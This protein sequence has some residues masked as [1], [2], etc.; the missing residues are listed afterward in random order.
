MCCNLMEVGVEKYCHAYF[1]KDAYIKQHQRV[2]HAV[3]DERYWPLDTC[4]PL[5]PPIL[6]RHVGRP[7]TMRAK[8]PGES[9]SQ[10]RCKM[11]GEVG[12][13]QKRCPGPPRK[14]RG[15]SNNEQMSGKRI[16][17]DGGQRGGGQRARDGGQRGGG[18]G[19]GGAQGRASGGQI[20]GGQ[21][22]RSGTRSSSRLNRGAGDSGHGTQD[23]TVLTQ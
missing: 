3:S 19:R 17:T 16:R 15:S 8:E 4:I 20:D 6:K 18:Q 1:S 2:I 13:L 12:H 22:G 5:S 7:K 9:T 23:S 11:C 10:R 14:K 21:R